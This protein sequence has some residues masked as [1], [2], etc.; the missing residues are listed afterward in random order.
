M[1][2]DHDLGLFPIFYA[3][4]SLLGYIPSFCP[5]FLS[6][7]EY[8]LVN[9]VLRFEYDVLALGFGGEKLSKETVSVTCLCS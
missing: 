4:K 7:L 2:Y 5:F 3:L 8:S 9:L 6:K 1:I